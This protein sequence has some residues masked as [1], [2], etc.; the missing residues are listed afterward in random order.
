[1][2]TLTICQNEPQVRKENIGSVVLFFCHCA[3]H[4]T[5]GEAGGE[6]GAGWGVFGVAEDLAVGVEGDGVAAL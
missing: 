6:W 4:F 2:F 5:S 3:L 1:M